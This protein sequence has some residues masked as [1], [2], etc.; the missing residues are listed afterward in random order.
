M[1]TEYTDKLDQMLKSARHLK[2]FKCNFRQ[3]FPKP[4]TNE[5][6]SIIETIHM[7]DV[8]MKV[9]NTLLNRCDQL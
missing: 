3:I 7:E 4:M 6:E 2:L 5:V 1:T 9:N 8:Y